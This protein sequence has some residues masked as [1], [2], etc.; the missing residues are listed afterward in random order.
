MKH[1]ILSIMVLTSTFGLSE[2][3]GQGDPSTWS[4]EKLNQWF[5]Q[6][7]WHKG[8]AVTPDPSTNKAA[9]AKAYF[10]NPDRWN[11]AFSFLKEKDLKTIEVKR[12]D[13]DGDNLYVL[14]SEYNTKNPEDAKYEAHRKYIDIQY[15]VTGK[16]LIGIAPITAKETVSQEYNGTKD[17]EY[18]SVK[19]GTMMQANPSKFFIFFPADAHMPNLKDGANS[20]VRKVVIKVRID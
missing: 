4:S 12:H 8:W 6:G 5:N 1:I 15:V 11:K 3:L 7:D 2:S 16:E 19:K 13:I 14:V 17:I 10:K 9:L 18:F 20:P